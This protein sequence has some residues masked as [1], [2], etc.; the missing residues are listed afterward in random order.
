MAQGGIAAIYLTVASNSDERAAIAAWVRRT[1]EPEYEKLGPASTNETFDKRELRAQLF[2]LLGNYGKDPAVL[3]E[4]NKIAQQYLDDPSSVDPTLGQTALIASAQ[5][6]NAELFGKLQSVYETSTNPELK[7]TALRLMAEFNNLSLEQRALDYAI[8]GKVRNQDAAIQFAIA[9]AIPE[10]RETAWSFIKSHWDQ[11]HALLTPE[12][13]QIL[14]TATGSFCSAA[15]RTDVENF[16][17]TH[18]VEAADVSVKHALERI[19]GCM[20]LRAQQEP[21]LKQW[22][23]GQ[24]AGKS[25]QSLLR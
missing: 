8:S 11:V 14:V 2:S 23:S 20:E 24:E 4:A 6:G 13:G 1:F 15:Q 9:L 18:K 7:E 25:L 12:L 16:F 17:S 22:L 21:S 5:N 10:T 3:N 19:N